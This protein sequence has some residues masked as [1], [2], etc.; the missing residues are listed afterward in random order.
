MPDQELIDCFE[1]LL[2]IVFITVHFRKDLLHVDYSWAPVVTIMAAAEIGKVMS[3]AVP[4]R[5]GRLL[6]QGCRLVAQE[7][8]NVY[9]PLTRQHLEPHTTNKSGG[10]QVE[11]LLTAELA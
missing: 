2:L 9:P 1:K 3:A 4:P 10:R 8:P 5:V 11:L 6:F 7:L